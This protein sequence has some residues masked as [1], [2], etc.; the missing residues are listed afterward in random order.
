MA[1]SPIVL[2]PLLD[3]L[4]T[5]SAE[6]Y[7]KAGK[8][9]KLYSVKRKKLIKPVGSIEQDSRILLS[10][11]VGMFRDGKLI[12]IYFPKEIM[13]DAASY[14]MDTPSKY[15]FRA[16]EDSSYANLTREGEKLLLEELPEF[17]V[18]STKMTAIA[19]E[20]NSD[21]LAL[22]QLSWREVLAYLK[23]KDPEIENKIMQK[24]LAEV[25]KINPSTF[26]RY[27]R[28]IYD[29]ARS[30]KDI[31]YLKEKLSYSFKS[32][33][34][35]RVEELDEHV[36]AWATYFHGFL[37]ATT[38]EKK[39]KA[40]KWSWLSAR[41]YPEADWDSA[42]WLAKLFLLLFVLDDTT[43]N[44]PLGLKNRFWKDIEL[45]FNEVISNKSL[46]ASGVMIKKYI[47]AFKSLWDD[48][49]LIH[50]GD[51]AYIRF[52]T[53]QLGQYLEAKRRESSNK[54]K[55][56]VPTLADYQLY[57]PVF[58]GGRLAIAFTSMGMG[59][60]FSALAEAWEETAHVRGLAE[61]L[62]VI[63]KDLFSYQKVKKANDFHNWIPVL[64]N[65]EGMT[66]DQARDY[67]IEK[68]ARLV[69]EFMEIN[70]EWTQQYNP[71]KDLELAI[72]KQ[73][74][75]KVSGA[76]EWSIKDTKR[77]LK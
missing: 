14:F 48:F 67:L 9:V 56:Q 61:E 65:A 47:R 7:R 45:G 2:K 3:P 76:V 18:L 26:Y 24:H 71:D 63:T 27:R 77:Y 1:W 50:R 35:D 25:L 73:L 15:E 38:D 10:G 72:L 36:F 8:Y 51:A 41:L 29:Q 66:E 16:F 37:N 62:I 44:L 17:S 21:W 5:V 43:D 59:T 19:Q 33:I 46:T 12:R 64:V 75:Y 53:D 69:N 52:I 40:M 74:K 42:C 58:S 70:A 55:E 34:Y 60:E 6:S 68:H 23:Y 13:M 39:Y 20:S 54:D 57:R 30:K 32:E 49:N 4:E 28:Q 22:S 11:L 31:R